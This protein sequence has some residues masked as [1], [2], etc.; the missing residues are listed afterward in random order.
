[1]QAVRYHTWQDPGPSLTG[2]EPP[3][4]YSETHHRLTGTLPPGMYPDR[5]RAMCL[6]NGTRG[7]GRRGGGAVARRSVPIGMDPRQFL[8][9]DKPIAQGGFKLDGTPGSYTIFSG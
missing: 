5:Y 7:G 1:M 3:C 2:H 8:A 4:K 6:P 9:A